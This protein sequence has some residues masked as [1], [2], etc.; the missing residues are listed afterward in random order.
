[1]AQHAPITH[2]A[3]TTGLT[4][5]ALSIYMH[6]AWKALLVM[7]SISLVLMSYGHIKFLMGKHA[8]AQQKQLRDRVNI[9]K[10]ESIQIEKHHKFSHQVK[11][12]FMRNYKRSH[13]SLSQG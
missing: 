3:T 1:M 5:G 12:V 4:S 6:N 9:K 2:I 11:L 7:S 8:L 13:R 10:L